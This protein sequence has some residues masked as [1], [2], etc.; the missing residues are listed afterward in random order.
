MKQLKKQYVVILVAIII[1]INI[2][3]TLYFFNKYEQNEKADEL[4]QLI[5]SFIVDDNDNQQ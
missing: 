1:G 2:I 5:K 4:N 3:G